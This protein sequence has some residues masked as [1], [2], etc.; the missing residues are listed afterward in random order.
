MQRT[1]D[2]TKSAG[3]NRVVWNLTPATA[4]GQQAGGFAGF[5]GGRGGFGVV[6]PGT[7]LVTLEV[8]GK[9]LTKP[10]QVLQDRWLGER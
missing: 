8:G 5:G 2:G 9:K 4:P 1:I 3:I 6:E 10:V 7:Y